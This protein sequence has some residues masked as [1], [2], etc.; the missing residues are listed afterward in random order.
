MQ[1][2]ALCI[3]H[4]PVRRLE[5]RELVLGHQRRRRPT[6]LRQSSGSIRGQGGGGGRRRVDDGGYGGEGP[7]VICG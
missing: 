6:L 5:A 1:I 3:F 4:E 7:V 2:A